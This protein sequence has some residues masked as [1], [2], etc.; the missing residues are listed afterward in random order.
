[1]D[2]KSVMHACSMS[3]MHYCTCINVFRQSLP[4]MPGCGSADAMQLYAYHLQNISCLQVVLYYFQEYPAGYW[5]ELTIHFYFRRRA[6]WY[7]LQAYL[8]SYLTICISWISFYL[9]SGIAARTLLGVNSMLA[10]TFQ[11]GNI[12]QNLPRVS[13]VKAIGK[14]ACIFSQFCTVYCKTHAKCSLLQHSEL[15]N[16]SKHCS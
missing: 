5:D 10:L 16:S 4:C 8:P 14:K 2:S 3:S 6:G 11:F 7:I 12:I 9:G 15:K 13:Y 1:M